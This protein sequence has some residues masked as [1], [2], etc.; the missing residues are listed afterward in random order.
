MNL[1]FL[2][3]FL[4]VLSCNSMDDCSKVRNGSFYY[5]SKANDA[6]VFIERRD[7]IQIETNS[8]LD[9]VLKSKIVW[10]DNCS[11]DLFVNS[12]CETKLETLDSILAVNPARVEILSITANYY[13]CKSKIDIDAYKF[14]VET[15]DTMY[16]EKRTQ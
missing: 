5:Y 6:K 12:L 8:K 15:I 1:N 3:L 4:L 14:H 11:F 10:K 7:T 2:A 16:F 13:I 9:K